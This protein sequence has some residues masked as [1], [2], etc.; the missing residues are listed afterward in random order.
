MTAARIAWAELRQAQIS[1]KTVWTFVRLGAEDGR[2]G[3]G[4]A[5]LPTGHETLRAAADAWLGEVVGAPATRASAAHVSAGRLSLADA[6]LRSALDMALFDL[7][8]Q[9]CGAPV[10]TLLGGAARDWIALYANINRTI[11]DRSPAGFAV[12]ARRAV[13]A[14]FAA[15]KIAPFDEIR[16]ELCAE[17]EFAAHLEV[18]L[19]RAAAVR[20]AIGAGA[21]LRLDCHWRFDP[22]GARAMIDA[23]AALRPDWIECPIDEASENA[24]AIAELRRFANRLG[25]RLAGLEMGVSVQYFEPYLSA[26]SY[27]VIMPDVK[28]LGGL[29]SFEELVAA[30]RGHGAALSPHNPTGPICHAASLHVCAA[31]SEIDELEL[32]FDESPLFDALLDGPPFEIRGGR[33][34]APTGPGLGVSLNRAQLDA[35]DIGAVDNR[36]VDIGAVDIGAANVSPARAERGG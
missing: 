8:G 35:V 34:R 20:E 6:A 24:P 10:S 29:A 2:E 1:P 18:G 32:Q 31:L 3:V 19:A 26:G 36:A 23:A 7:E 17:A 15:V 25:V 30:A 11:E 21:D 22:A 12:A 5:T 9:A 28:Y 33:C 14:G 27:D 13:D 4:E 16:P